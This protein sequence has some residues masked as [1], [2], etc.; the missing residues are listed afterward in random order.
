MYDFY[1]SGRGYSDRPIASPTENTLSQCC[2]YT[3]RTSIYGSGPYRE[4]KR[5]GFRQCKYLHHLCLYS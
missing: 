1:R 2:E 5:H 4:R 3:Q